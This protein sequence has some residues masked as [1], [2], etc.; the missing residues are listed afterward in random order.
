MCIPVPEIDPV[1]RVK[2][3][4]S[5]SLALSCAYLFLPWWLPPP[6]SASNSPNSREVGVGC[7]VMMV[8][9]FSAQVSGTANV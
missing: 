2:T 5:V 6:F 9:K 8:G 1:R 7:F 4:G 3:E